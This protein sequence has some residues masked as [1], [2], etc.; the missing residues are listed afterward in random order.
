MDWWSYQ[1]C[2]GKEVRQF[3][4]EPDGS[5]TSDWSMGV[6]VPESDAR[7][8]TNEHGENLVQFYADGQACDE[9]AA[10]RSTKVIYICCLE[11]TEDVSM[12]LDIYTLTNV[13]SC[14]SSLSKVSRSLLFVITRSN[15]ASPNFVT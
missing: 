8:Q 6:Y 14:R 13:F 1:I 3:H 7:Y 9:N 5:K 4:R 10:K 11:K 15:Y 2:Y 12:T